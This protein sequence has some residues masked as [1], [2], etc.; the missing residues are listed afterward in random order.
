MH[1]RSFLLLA[2]ALTT[3]SNTGARSTRAESSVSREIV[4]QT[5][6]RFASAASGRGAAPA[7]ESAP[8]GRRIASLG[9]AIECSL[10]DRSLAA[11]AAAD[12]NA[13]LSIARATG[14]DPAAR[15]FG[16]DRERVWLLAATDSAAALDAMRA[17]ARDPEIDWVE[18]NQPREPAR[19]SLS[20]GFPNDPLFQD[21]RQWGLANAGLAGAYGG[22]AGADV[23]AL[24]AWGWCAGS[25]DLRLAV[26]DTGID[27]DHPDLGGLI[28]GRPRIELGVNLS[29]EASP[30]FADSFGHGTP[31]AGV[32]AARTGEGAHF[33]TLGIAGLC[34]GDGG[35]NAGCRIVPIKIAPGHSG[36][37]SSFSIAGAILYAADVGARAVNVSFAGSGPSRLE[38]SALYDAIRRGCVAVTGIGNRGDARPQYPAAY[39]ADGLCIAVGASDPWDRRASFSSFG[40]GLDLLAPGVSIWT[41]FMTYPSVNGARYDGYVAGSGTSFAA[42]FVT[43]AVGLLSAA[44][45]ELIDADFQH[46]LRESADDVGAAGVDSETAYGRLNVARA[47]EAVRPTFGIWHDEVVANAWS[48][49]P[50]DSLFV[51]EAGPG[52]MSAARPWPRARRFE[53]TTAVALPDSFLDSIRVWPR[54]GGTMTVRGGFRL[55][56]FV[57]WAEVSSMRSD[58]FTLRGYLYRSGDCENADCPDESWLPLP[59][60]QARF[61]FTVIGRVDRPPSL[62]L[63]APT[64]GARFAPRDTIGLRWFARDPDRITSFQ[65]WLAAGRDSMLLARPAGNDTAATVVIPCPA[66]LRGAAR[67]RVIALDENGRHHDR[68]AREIPIVITGSCASAEPEAVAILEAT[69]NPFTR[70]LRIAAPRGVRVSIVDVGGRVVRRALPMDGARGYE[71]DG[72]DESGR[73]ARPGI[74]FVAA[75][76]SSRRLKILKLE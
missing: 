42:P 43:G 12:L 24:E 61:G 4:V 22:I 32:M 41:T 5:T 72:R 27:P 38:R 35:A 40:P 46:L 20:S 47:L 9:L 25:N 51:G 37:A 6:R 69:P 16:L 71:W 7:L 68:T 18:P 63:A 53:A 75:R 76:G 67:L 30:S 60:D 15:L 21:T 10:A 11:L 13:R 73:D 39:A 49:G 28:E 44:R 70:S 48:A 54:A 2:L 57:P 55:P 23:H 59:P 33:D 31:V 74:Y 3:V 19:T 45:P 17:L 8:L 65:I 62:E 29:G 36:L 26:A 1:A 50:V 14:S 34:G 64:P 56:Y 52:T 66:S 58:S